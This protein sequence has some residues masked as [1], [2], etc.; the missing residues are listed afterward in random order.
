MK[1]QQQKQRYF[2]KIYYELSYKN[3]IVA[4]YLISGN[5]AVNMSKQGFGEGTIDKNNV[6]VSEKNRKSIGNIWEIICKVS[7][8]IPT[9][10]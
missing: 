3:V 1:K 2:E 9:Q 10:K 8:M 6:A 5:R 4:I 7:I